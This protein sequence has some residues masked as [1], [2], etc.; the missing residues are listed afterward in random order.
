MVNKKYLLYLLCIVLLTVGFAGVY[1]FHKGSELERG[2]EGMKREVWDSTYYTE[3]EKRALCAGIDDVT[4]A[5]IIDTGSFSIEPVGESFE[6]DE[7]YPKLDAS[8][9]YV[10]IGDTGRHIASMS[11]IDSETYEILFDIPIA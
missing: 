9:W 6:P 11:V 1:R 2:K 5:E 3:A 4:A 8:D 7:R 10:I